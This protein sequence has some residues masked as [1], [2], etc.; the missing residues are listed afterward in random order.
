MADLTFT[1][2][3]DESRVLR[4]PPETPLGEVEVVVREKHPQGNGAAILE[5]IRNLP[6]DVDPAFWQRARE[7]LFRSRDEWDED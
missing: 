1:A 2:V 5:A 3:V 7:E 6:R 4:L